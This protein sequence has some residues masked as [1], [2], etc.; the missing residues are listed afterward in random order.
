LDIIEPDFKDFVFSV[1]LSRP[2][3]DFPHN[4]GAEARANPRNLKAQKE[5]TRQNIRL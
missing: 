2:D 3:T 1:N 4:Q 5:G